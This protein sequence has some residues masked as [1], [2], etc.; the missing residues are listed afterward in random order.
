VFGLKGAIFRPLFFKP[1]FQKFSGQVCGGLQVHA[2]D[3]KRFRPYL[4]GLAILK[5]LHDLY[6]SQFR[7]REKPYEFVREIPAIDLLTGSD[8]FRRKLESGKSW[9]E[10][11]SGYEEGKPEFLKVRKNYL[12]Y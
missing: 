11:R 6:P 9:K 1:T 7:W 10:I 5:A 3:R 12:L 8:R 4:T 2:T